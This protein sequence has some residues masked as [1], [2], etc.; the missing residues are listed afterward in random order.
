MTSLVHNEL[1]SYQEKSYPLFLHGGL[2]R[3]LDQ[4][5]IISFWQ[6]SNEVW[7]YNTMPWWHHPM[8]TISAP[9]AICPWNSPVTGEFPAHKPVTRSFG[10]FFDLHLNKRLSKQS[11]RW[12]FKTPSRPLWR[13]C[14][15]LCPLQRYQLI[16]RHICW[17]HSTAVYLS[18]GRYAIQLWK[19]NM[20]STPI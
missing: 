15:G 16:F 5:N 20:R 10:I 13:H 6:S 19:N 14:N 11:W 2:Y 4:C 17:P 9:L 1:I 12:W 8:V 3:P 18:G 7:L